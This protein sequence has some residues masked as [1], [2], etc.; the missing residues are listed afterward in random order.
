MPSGGQPYPLLVLCGMLPWLFFS[1]AMADSGNSLVGNSSLISK[2]YFPRLVIAISS[3]ITSFVDFL[4]SAL[5]LVVLMIWYHYLPPLTV[6]FLPFFV[7][8][9]FGASIGVGLWIAALMVK[10]RDF[11]FIVPFV[12]QF[13]LYIS[14][15]GFSSSVIPDRFRLLYALNP[16]VG[17]IDGFRWCLLGAQNQIYWP[18]LAAALIDVILLLV[19]GVWYFRKTEQT[20]ADVI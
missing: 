4:I 15:V 17:I 11:R 6:V 2:V 9:A 3:V 10:Y 8:L 20:F 16:M 12:I 1:N 5:L 7:L 14:P 19:S 18:A 13:G